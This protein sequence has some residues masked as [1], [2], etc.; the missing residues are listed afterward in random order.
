MPCVRFTFK[1]LQHLGVRFSGIYCWWLCRCVNASQYLLYLLFCS[2][3]CDSN[4]VTLVMWCSFWHGQTWLRVY[5][6]L[7]SISSCWIFGYIKNC[8]ILFN[9]VNFVEE[10][11]LL[12][13]MSFRVFVLSR[14]YYILVYSLFRN[15]AFARHLDVVNFWCDSHFPGYAY[16][17][18]WSASASVFAISHL[19]TLQM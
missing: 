18:D 10:F 8:S 3:F 11:M 17:Q 7:S 4:N 6:I 13:V 9:G 2:F 14:S 15:S 5:A 1:R 19:W 16:Q 12:K